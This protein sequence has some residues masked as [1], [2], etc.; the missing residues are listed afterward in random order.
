M[1]FR[2]ESYRWIPVSLPAAR[3]LELIDRPAADA[4]EDDPLFDVM[5]AH[6]SQPIRTGFVLKEYEDKSRLYL[7]WGYAVD[8]SGRL[9][10]TLGFDVPC[11]LVD[12]YVNKTFNTGWRPIFLVSDKGGLCR[13]PFARFL[14][15][16][17][18]PS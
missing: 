4:T 10:V 9:A 18:S 11:S 7:T 15:K 12:L 6:S 14:A 13:I 5:V 8:E 3:V 1:R 2:E 16:R 17:A